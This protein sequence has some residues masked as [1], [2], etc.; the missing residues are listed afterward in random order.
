MFIFY[1]CKH[2]KSFL[3][4]QLF[5]RFF[6]PWMA[7]FGPLPVADEACRMSGRPRACFVRPVRG[8][9][10]RIFP[11][12]QVVVPLD[13][14]PQGIL[15]VAGHP[16]ADAPVVIVAAVLVDRQAGLLQVVDAAGRSGA[17]PRL[18]QRRQKHRRE[19][20]DNR[21]NDE[22]LDQGERFC[23]HFFCPFLL[24]MNR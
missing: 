23:S 20:G 1:M 15:V 11:G 16:A 24:G 6:R 8:L 19:D 5:V 18:V 14:A 13:A 17:V 3:I 7:L 21:D 9:A 2:N 22:K 4:M 10:G 12:D